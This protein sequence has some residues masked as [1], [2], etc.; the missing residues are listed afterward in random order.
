[1]TEARKESMIDQ[2]LSPR[3][4]ATHVQAESSRSESLWEMPSPVCFLGDS[5]SSQVDDED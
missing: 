2:E 4:A 5:N 1:M 3:G